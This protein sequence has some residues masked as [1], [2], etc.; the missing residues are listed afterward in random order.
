MS[1]IDLY[2]TQQEIKAYVKAN[3]PWRVVSGGFPEAESIPQ[4][5]GVCEVY[6]ILRFSNMMPI[7]NGGSFAGA[8]HDEYYSYVDAMCVGPTDDLALELASMVTRLLT[9]KKFD[10]TG[11]LAP[12]YGGGQFALASG[13]AHPAA[14]IAIT[15]FRYTINQSDVGSGSLVV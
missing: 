3:V 8:A 5:N 2:G 9:G 12:N 11:E 13:T 1:G 7:T 6:V 4:V 15:P 10:N 14:F